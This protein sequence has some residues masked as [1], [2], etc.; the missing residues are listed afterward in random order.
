VKVVLG[1]TTVHVGDIFFQLFAI[2]FWVV[3]IGLVVIL[4][5]NSMKKN[6]QLKRVEKKIDRLIEQIEKSKANGL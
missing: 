5:R 1:S 6:E 3:M 4:F 2:L